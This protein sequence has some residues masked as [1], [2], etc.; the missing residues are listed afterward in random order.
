MLSVSFKSI[1]NL[2]HKDFVLVPQDAAAIA[3]QGT[4]SP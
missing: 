1:P 2:E 3:F 4:I